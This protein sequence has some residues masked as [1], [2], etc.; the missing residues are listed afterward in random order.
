MTNDKHSTT[1]ESICDNIETISTL[2]YK[3]ITNKLN[4]YQNEESA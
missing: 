2:I 1:N 4:S 3:A